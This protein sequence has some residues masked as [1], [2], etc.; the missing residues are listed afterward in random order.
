MQGI[1]RLGL[2]LE[3]C[4]IQDIID[5]RGQFEGLEKPLDLQ[6]IPWLI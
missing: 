2:R 3:S 5:E 1:K 4:L 6:K